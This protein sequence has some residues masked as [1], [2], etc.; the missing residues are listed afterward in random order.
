MKRQDENL[1][2]YTT[3]GFLFGVST[4]YRIE[5]DYG[6]VIAC[7]VETDKKHKTIKFYFKPDGDHAVS[8]LGLGRGYKVSYPGEGFIQKKS[9]PITHWGED[10]ITVYY[11]NRKYKEGDLVRVKDNGRNC[12][13]PAGITVKIIKALNIDDTKP[14]L[15]QTVEGYTAYW[16][17]EEDLEDES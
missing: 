14:Y 17:A 5:H 7:D 2:S 1:V 12:T 3:R 11:G 16:Y 10:H 8:S 13:H 9:Y 15:C 6:S 4:A